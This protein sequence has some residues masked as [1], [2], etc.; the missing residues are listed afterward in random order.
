[1]ATNPI[2]FDRPAAAEPATSAM[3]RACMHK[4]IRDVLVTRILD[5]TYPPEFRFKELTLAREF[6]VNQGPVRGRYA[7]RSGTRA[8]RHYRGTRVHG[9]D[10]GSCAGPT[11]CAAWS[12]ARRQIVAMVARP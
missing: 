2:K 5:G 1:M 12:G 6:N 8:V 9:V 3:N 10:V 4:R 7:A 11:S